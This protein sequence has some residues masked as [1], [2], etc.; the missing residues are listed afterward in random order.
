[1]SKELLG[2]ALKPVKVKEAAH[3]KLNLQ[4]AVSPKDF[5]S[6]QEVLYLKD[7]NSKASAKNFSVNLDANFSQNINNI[8]ELNVALHGELTVE[9]QRCM[10]PMQILIEQKFNY[11]LVKNAYEAEKITDTTQELIILDEQ[12][13]PANLRDGEL[14]LNALAIEEILLSVSFYPKHSEDVNCQESSHDLL[15]DYI[16]G[17]SQVTKND[18]DETSNGQMEEQ[19]EKVQRPFANLKD[20]IKH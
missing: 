10:G 14:D 2:Q 7:S 19:E 13:T 11:L 20:L 15:E 18:L 9:C 6:M 8:P 12:E 17:E 3:S 1:M 4:H 5:V 16:R